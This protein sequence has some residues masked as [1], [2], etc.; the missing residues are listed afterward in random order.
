[1]KTVV[2]VHGLDWR[3]E[4]WGPI[5][6]LFLRA[7]ELAATRF[8]NATI[9]VSKTL[10]QYFRDRGR[11]VHFIPN[12]TPIPGPASDVRARALGLEPGRYVLFVGRL[13]P[14]KGVHLLCEAHARDAADWTLAI[15]GE[16][17]FT[18][19]YVARCRAL[20]GANTR[21]LGA[22]YGEDLASLWQHAGLVVLPSSMEG[23]SIALLEAMS[24][25][26]A[27]L[28]SDIPENVEVL[29]G[30]GTT[31]RSGD[32]ASLGREMRR[33]LEAPAIRTERG[34]KG[35]ARIEERYGWDRVV[36]ETL[37]IYQ[38]LLLGPRSH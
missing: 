8:P 17:H 38:N 13:V 20:S 19:E 11:A 30:I 34:D 36:Q 6:S 31:F 37:K 33:L 29:E 12:G 25:G 15:A 22:V 1:M 7:C 28:A 2:T 5:A 4:K 27:V 3:R 26:R 32:A 21:F 18:D 14:E 35:R 24:F 23:L 16:A 10:E 9:V